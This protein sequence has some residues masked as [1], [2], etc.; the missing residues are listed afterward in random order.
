MTERFESLLGDIEALRRRAAAFRLGGY[1]PY[2]FQRAFHRC[3][4]GKW[5]R[6]VF[7]DHG[8]IA[9][10]VLLS[11]G[12]QAGKTQ[13]GA[14]DVAIHATGEY[15]AW[16]DGPDLSGMLREF[17]LLWCGGANN[18]RVRDI[19][20]KQL[21]G[22]PNDPKAWGSGW[23]PKA[24]LVDRVL[25][26]GVRNA[27]DTV[28]VRHKDGFLVTIAFK[29]YDSSLLDWAGDPVALIWLDEEPPQ[30]VYSQCVARTTATGGWVKMTFT[31]EHGATEVV[32][33]F[34]TR[35]KVGQLLLLV[36]LDDARHGDG[37]GHLNAAIRAQ[38]EEVYLP[39]ERDM[40]IRGLP[41]LG[42]GAVFPLAIE[43]ILCEPF[44]IPP[45]MRRLYGLDFGRGGQNHPTAAVWLAFDPEL[46]SCW[47]YDVYKS[48]ATET[49]VHGQALRAR[50]A[51]IPAA[52]P[53]DGHRKE[54]YATA[55]V[56]AAYRSMGLNLLRQHALLE[57]G[58]DDDG[59]IAVEPGI[60]LLYRAMLEGRF[61]VFSNLVPWQ[62]E[63]RMYHRA[64][65]DGSIVPIGDD[66]MSATR[67]GYVMR[68][69][70]RAAN[71]D[72]RE[73]RP[74]DHKRPYSPLEAV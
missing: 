71:L 46:K 16:W 72:L 33:G 51:W 54:S 36:G 44:P 25:K 66:L 42:S 20:Q 18:D 14:A 41:V 74:A 65:T 13:C 22:D 58:D 12:N 70:A 32:S 73:T 64:E 7:E 28:T 55:G 30:I 39:H 40:R 3:R 17:P 60:F 68:R 26:A 49:A 52:W 2:P 21:C 10:Q 15:P 1:D 31:P 27:F 4:S 48:A 11:A 5:Q 67:I 35:L 34:L 9:K 19:C 43:T 37:R 47:V 29:S 61:R 62:E 45:S 8:A 50:G 53:H 6:G 23:L 38:L 63:F 57:E 59:T 24:V 56:A 69:K